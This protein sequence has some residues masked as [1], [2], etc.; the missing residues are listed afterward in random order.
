MPGRF[1]DVITKRTVYANNA[2]A[3]SG[4]QSWMSLPLD[5]QNVKVLRNK[6]RF[7]GVERLKFSMLAIH[8]ILVAPQTNRNSS[9]F[10]LTEIQSICFMNTYNL[11]LKKSREWMSSIALAGKCV[12]FSKSQI[13]RSLSSRTCGVVSCSHQNPAM[14]LRSQCLC[15]PFTLG[16]RANDSNPGKTY[17][18]KDVHW[19]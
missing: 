14:A 8:F 13:A 12:F 11:K 7:I 2:G 4:G 19:N 5:I 1:R 17:F 15:K 6:L 16:G 18:F 9:P 10:N 3:N